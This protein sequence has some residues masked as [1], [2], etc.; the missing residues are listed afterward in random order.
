MEKVAQIKELMLSVISECSGRNGTDR[1]EN[2]SFDEFKNWF[3][4]DIQYNS[5]RTRE[6]G[7]KLIELFK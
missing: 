1:F 7:E 3:K 6:M 2:L 4:N 5:P